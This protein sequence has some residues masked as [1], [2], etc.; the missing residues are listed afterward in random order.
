MSPR[1][2]LEYRLLDSAGPRECRDVR[3]RTATAVANL[4]GVIA[5][6]PHARL[7]QSNSVA[8]LPLGLTKF[9]GR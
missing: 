5:G 6:D 2:H 8:V 9:E 1:A 4:A 7:T 3:R